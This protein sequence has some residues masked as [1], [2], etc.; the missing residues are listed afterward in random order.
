MRGVW[1]S[2]VGRG[3]GNID[4]GRARKG[5]TQRVARYMAKYMGKSFA[6]GR[7]LNRKRYWSSESVNA[8]PAL[9]FALEA[10]AFPADDVMAVLEEITPLMG[11][12]AK[13]AWISDGQGVIWLSG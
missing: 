11:G 7:E 1:W 3:Q 13:S 12:A 5:G 8:K 9:Q 4:L 2:I 10:V 6:D